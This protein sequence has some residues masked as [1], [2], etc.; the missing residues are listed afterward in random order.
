MG[1]FT[2]SAQSNTEQKGDRLYNN[3]EFAPAIHY[4]EKE[5]ENSDNL[6]VKRKLAN[7][8][9]KTLKD[10]KANHLLESI[11]NSPDVTAKDYLLYAN[12]LKRLRNYSKAKVWFKKYA[13][14]HPE[15]KKINSLILSCGLINEL[16][17]TQLYTIKSISVNSPQTDFASG[18]YKNGLAFVSGRKNNTSKEIDGK[19]GE[20]YLDMYFSEKSGDHFLKPE[21]FSNQFNTKYHE[22]PACFSANEKF[23]FFTRNEG[24]LNLEGKSELNL[25]SARHDG[26][27]W[28]KAELFQFSGKNYSMAHPSLS[29]DGRYLYFISNMDGGYG[30]TDIYVCTKFGFSWSS[31]INCGSS[32][33]TA[34][35]EMFPFIA[36]DG[37]LY[38]ASDGHIG[39]GGLDIFKSIFEQN[40]WT[41]PVNLGPP[42]NTSK[43]DFGYL[44]RK[45]KDLGYFSSNRNGSDDIFEFKQNAN[46]IKNLTGKI[47]ANNSKTDLKDVKII[48][49]EN[50]SKEKINFSDE[51]GHFSFKIFEGKNYSLI[52][53]KPGF[54]TKRILYFAQNNENTP[55]KL[56]ISMD[57]TQWVKLN[58]N[59]IDQYSARAVK[60]ANI[61]II[62]QTYRSNSFSISD[63]YGD[64]EQDIEPDVS[65][66]IIIQKKGYFTKVINNYTYQSDKFEQIELQKFSTNQDLELYGVEFYSET[67]ELKKNSIQELNNLASLLKVNPH[68]SIE[69]S[70]FTDQDRG[71]KENN[72]LCE[73]RAKVA[74]EYIISKGITTNRVHYKSS[75]FDSG[76]SALVVKLTES[77]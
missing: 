34:G 1:V 36:E 14:L 48:L 22:G 75:G 71:N 6:D 58:G 61:Q 4:Y 42:F 40:E 49:M 31:P 54:K 26:D 66:E 12:L 68:I 41:F 16:E 72:I 10:T 45:N 30:G 56:N 35:N 20:Y 15:D 18:F 47:I 17:D 59:I 21:P 2:S 27:K 19:I 28:D 52:V 63:E 51:K 46:K 5:L 76:R 39:F 37:Y 13:V 38:F 24:N 43:D 65:Y 8:Y 29:R 67:S 70:G 53:T 7:C 62:N 73:K 23:I 11:V 77:F 25:Y 9:I 3:N 32:I 55:K 50:L 57:T 64:F 44:I 69:I 33:N 60:K 74:A